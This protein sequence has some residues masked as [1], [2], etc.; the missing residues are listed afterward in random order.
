M[1]EI[2]EGDLV[3]QAAKNFAVKYGDGQET[4]C[5]LA[6]DYAKT[7]DAEPG[8]WVLL[9]APPSR[10]GK[11]K[12]KVKAKPAAPPA[13]PP[14]KRAR[15]PVLSAAEQV[16]AMSEAEREEWRAALGL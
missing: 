16:A 5:L 7:V 11:G 6:D 10:V 13:A 4:H 1:E 12:G 9:A 2:Y 15:V 8:S 3:G 14:A